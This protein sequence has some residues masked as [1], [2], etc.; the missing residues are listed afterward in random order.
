MGV[1]RV[2]SQQV[3]YV[4]TDTQAMQNHMR[5]ML[6][7]VS[8]AG[9]TLD[10]AA[11]KTRPEALLLPDDPTYLPDLAMADLA[12]DSSL[13]GLGLD[14]DLGLT[15][16]SESDRSR[17][18]SPHESLSS[19]TS[20]ESL[21]DPQIRIP[22][23]GSGGSFGGDLGSFDFGGDTSDAGRYSML[24]SGARGRIGRPEEEDG[25]LLLP[26]VDFE[27]D[28]EGNLIETG[29]KAAG[30]TARAGSIAPT[31]AAPR[32]IRADSD[33]SALERVRREQSE[34]R[35]LGLEVRLL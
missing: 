27:F 29:A 8:S 4:L 11:G 28:T 30:V 1:S 2:Y 6:R 20:L 24:G 18:L 26:E 7:S 22:T 16:A 17:L 13:Q 14:L 21:T 19:R 3:T 32:R 10:A 15:S 12:L 25:N 23:S 33:A 5:T 35:R 34:A 9:N 31:D